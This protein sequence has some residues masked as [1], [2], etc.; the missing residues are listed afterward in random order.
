MSVVIRPAFSVIELLI[1]LAIL[2]IAAAFVLPALH[3]SLE[4]S[5]LRSGAVNVQNAWGKA[6]SFAIREGRSM[7]FRCR[8]G[9]RIWKIE[10]NDQTIGTDILSRNAEPP[11]G[12]SADHASTNDQLKPDSGNRTLVCEGWLPNGVCF[13]NFE[14]VD[15]PREDDN[16]MGTRRQ[17]SS[18]DPYAETDWSQTLTFRPDGRCQDACLLIRGTD[19]FVI[20]VKIRGLTSG[21]TFTAPFRETQT[22][23]DLRRQQ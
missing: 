17:T 8:S 18:L 21:V 5:R 4:R 15:L 19:G 3:G 13:V 10:R 7:T 6:R 12:M 11:E 2:T 23:D 20:Q 22:S 14:P 9:G 1:V 16:R